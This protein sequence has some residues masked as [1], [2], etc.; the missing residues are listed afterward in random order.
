MFHSFGNMVTR[1][2][3]IARNARDAVES[4]IAAS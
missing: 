4:R 2:P 1:L 3:Y